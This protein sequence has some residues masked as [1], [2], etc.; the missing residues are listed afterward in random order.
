[1]FC[2]E[3]LELVDAIAAGDLT[4]DARITAHLASCTGCAGALETARRVDQLLRARPAPPPPA[5]FTSRIMGRI[6]RD[7]WRRDQFLDV[8]FNVAVGLVVVGILAV[9]WV[10]L[11]QTGFAG[12]TRDALAVMNAALVDFVRRVAPSLPVYGAA[13]AL[14]AT[15]LGVWWWAERSDAEI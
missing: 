1:M 6:R 14:L 7:R 13:G 2:D 8:G 5:N 10:V 11:S 12:V 3:L 4:P 15:A 9:L